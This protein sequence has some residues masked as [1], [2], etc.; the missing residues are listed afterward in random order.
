MEKILWD[1][2]QAGDESRGTGALPGDIDGT[3]WAGV[4]SWLEEWEGAGL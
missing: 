1:E 3:I 4:D 2:I